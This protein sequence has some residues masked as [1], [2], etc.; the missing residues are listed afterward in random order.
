MSPLQT[1]AR[2]GWIDR[3]LRVFADVRPGE[4]AGALLMFANIFL[5][6]VT[7]YI[8]KT[9]REPLILTH[10]GAE[11]KSY[12]AAAQALL[13]I[14]YVP[15]YSRV[16]SALPR[17]ALLIT[18]VLF[19]FGCLQVFVV[20]GQAQ[21]PYVGFAFFV[22]VGIFSLTAIAQFWSYANDIYRRDEGERLF[23][24]IAIG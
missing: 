19:F 17:R 4:G 23:A 15:I 3:S 2:P 11:L 5:L 1:A 6:L 14:V 13:L 22:W 16:A 8:L 7:Y 12:A 10:G 18:I 9:V 20:L 24:F 21:M